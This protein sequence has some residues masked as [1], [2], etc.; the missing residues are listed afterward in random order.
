MG[1]KS[2]KVLLHSILLTMLLLIGSADLASASGWVGENGLVRLSFTKGEELQ[3]V[4]NVSEGEGG[5]TIVDLYAYLTDVDP[6]KLNGEAFLGLGAMEMTLMIEGAEGKITSQ[7]FPVPCHSL[8]RNTGEVMAGIPDGLELE[9]EAT[10][11]VHWQIM[12]QGQPKNVVFRLDVDGGITRHR[13]E[14]VKEAQ[15]YAMYT[16]RLVSKQHTSLFGA[17]YVPAYLNYEGETDL[18][19]IRGKES[20]QDVGVYQKR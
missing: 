11:L 13:T 18:T 2:M 20:W 15:P 17:G 5:V 1:E 7:D 4:T 3:G 6:V 10:L 9:K 19:P 8:G 16:G 14:G 12:F